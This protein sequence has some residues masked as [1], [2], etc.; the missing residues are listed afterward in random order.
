ML[1]RVVIFSVA[2]LDTTP[3]TKALLTKAG[4]IG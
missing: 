4:V 1:R 2:I 3:T